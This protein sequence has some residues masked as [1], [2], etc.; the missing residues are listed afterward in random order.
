[1]AKGLESLEMEN[2]PDVSPPEALPVKTIG[3]FLAVTF[4]LSVFLLVATSSIEDDNSIAAEDDILNAAD[5]GFTTPLSFGTM[6]MYWDQRSA[7]TALVQNNV[8][9][10]GVQASDL[11]LLQIQQVSR[12]GSRFPTDNTMREIADLLYRL[13]ANY[14]SV[15]PEWLKEYSLPYN[16]SVAGVLSSSGFDELA[17]FGKRTRDSVG[18]A[19]PTTFER[20]QFILAHTFIERTGDSARAFASTFFDNP[21]DVHY[22]KYAKG[23]DPLLRFYDVCDRY[24]AEVKHNPNASAEL[25]AY[26][27]TSQMN[28]SLAD[29]KSQLNLPDSV[30]LSVSDVRAA[31]AA[32]A[33]DIMVYGITSH[34]CSLMDLTFLNRLDY[35][36]DL[37]A[38]YE[39]GAGYKINYEM[40]AVLLQDIHSYMKM[41]ISGETN[42][43]G[44]LRFGHAETTLPLMTLLGYGD[45]S[46]LLASWTD[47]QINSRAFRTSVL[48]P[49]ASNID[50]RLYRGKKDQ[51]Y[52]VSVWIQEVEAPLPGCDGEM[53]CELSKFEKIW[54]F[55]LNDYNFKT[56][57]ALPKKG[58]KNPHL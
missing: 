57:C 47:D 10:T 13:Q 55:Y 29:L 11:E 54:S 26:G 46:K 31:F 58:K 34:W 22:I 24:L 19:I 7:Q 51:K 25:K 39:Q 9:V 28:A 36:E 6:T 32:C 56:D 37:E 38:F 16:M 15:L 23:K 12:H 40:A 48:S 33:F 4:L 43:V 53:Y 2:P 8:R 21:S 35:A 3:R 50:F 44:N 52:Y 45:R 18:F 42:V 20:K 5:S 41:F 49:T 1:M 27:S 17:A 14:S 30:A